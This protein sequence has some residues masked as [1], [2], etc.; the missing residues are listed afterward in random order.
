MTKF[1]PYLSEEAI[2][3]DA[4][5]LLAEYAQARGVTIERPIPIEDIVEKHLKLG[6]EFDDMHRLF[7]VP[8][9]G[10]GSIPISSARSSSTSAGS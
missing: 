8:R 1:V 5:A 4:A 3:R 9:S 10:L 6:I 7:G 2:E